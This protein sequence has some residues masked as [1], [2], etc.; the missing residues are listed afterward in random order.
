MY[1]ALL[2]VRI[3][4]V[5]SNEWNHAR[6]NLSKDYRH[7]TVLYKNRGNETFPKDSRLKTP[8]Q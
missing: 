1:L 4:C 8:N 2:S 3:T 6:R 7:Q 5:T